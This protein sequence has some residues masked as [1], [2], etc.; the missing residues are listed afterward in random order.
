[1]LHNIF[2][3]SNVA[4]DG[5]QMTAA[6]SP[7]TIKRERIVAFSWQKWLREPTTN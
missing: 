1:M 6:S 2:F 4:R 5:P 7:T 3:R